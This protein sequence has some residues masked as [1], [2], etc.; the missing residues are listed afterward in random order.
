M[1][2]MGESP[3]LGIFIPFWLER[4]NQKASADIRQPSSS[5]PHINE[6]TRYLN[7]KETRTHCLKHNTY[8]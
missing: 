3:I 5:Y 1:C 2:E 8:L 7:Y 4:R 6:A